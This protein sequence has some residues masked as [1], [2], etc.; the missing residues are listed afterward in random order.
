MGVIIS[1]IGL[2]TWIS[3]QVAL[4]IQFGWLVPVFWFVIPWMQVNA[5][6]VLITYLQHTD[7]VVPHYS[8][9]EWDFLKGALATI[10]RD[11]GFLNVLFHHMYDSI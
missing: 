1:N 10:D 8:N 5:W 9:N 7:P 4:G 6:L 2:L 3:I 11:W